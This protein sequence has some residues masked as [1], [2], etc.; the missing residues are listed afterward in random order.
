MRALA[1]TSPTRW[2]GLPDV[3]K[4]AESG[5]PG[6]DARTWAGVMGPKNMPRP[7]VDRLNGE[8]QKIIAQPD[9]NVRLEAI[10]GGEVRGSA[11]EEMRAMLA[12]QVARWNRVVRDAKIQVD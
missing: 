7:L 9:I 10:V 2:Q 6:F 3:P 12:D 4:L 1:I 8:I 5:F 11:P